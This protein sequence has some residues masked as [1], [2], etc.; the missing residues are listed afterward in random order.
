M[1]RIDSVDELLALYQQPKRVSLEKVAARLGP[2]HRE[3]IEASRF[4]VLSTAGGG[5]VHG[6]PRGEDGPVV[7]VQD[8]RTLL[9]PDWRGNNRLDCLRD[10]VE[11]G[12]V[13]LLFMVPGCGVT[14]RVNGRAFLTDDAELRQGFAKGPSLPAT[15]VVVEIAEIY[16]QCA[17]AL[18]RSDLWKRDDSKAV[19]SLGSMLAEVSGGEFGGAEFDASYESD[20]AKR[21]W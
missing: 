4:A 14:V 9:L 16:V 5:G 17:K 7:R 18:M 15:V 8:D 13:A 10:I 21:L 19:P 6:S 1:R 3:W 11:D 12:R 20:A 2:L